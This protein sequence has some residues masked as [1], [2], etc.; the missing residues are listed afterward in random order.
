M[1]FTTANTIGRLTEEQKE[2][3]DQKLRADAE[4]FGEGNYNKSI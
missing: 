3:F 2:A 4:A 1:T